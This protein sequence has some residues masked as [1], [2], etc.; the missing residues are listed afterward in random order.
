ME[1]DSNSVCFKENKVEV[2]GSLAALECLP[3]AWTVKSRWFSSWNGSQAMA[4][5]RFHLPPHAGGLV[6]CPH[7]WTPPAPAL[8]LPGTPWVLQHVGEAAVSQQPWWGGAGAWCHSH[9][10][11]CRDSTLQCVPQMRNFKCKS[12]CAEIFQIFNRLSY[13]V[14][15]RGFFLFSSN[16]N[17]PMLPVWLSLLGFNI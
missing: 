11:A 7:H 14:L 12:S 8:A 17:F 5:Q 10:P 1:A 3:Q 4:G 15:S 2:S 13:P 16:L 9:A 6:P